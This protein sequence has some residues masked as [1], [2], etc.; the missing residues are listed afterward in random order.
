MVV[1]GGLPNATCSMLKV[2][3]VVFIWVRVKTD[4]LL[5]LIFRI[6]F[7]IHLV[8]NLGCFFWLIIK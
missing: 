3:K 1:G 6:L 7:R 2:L 4:T 8:H 5:M